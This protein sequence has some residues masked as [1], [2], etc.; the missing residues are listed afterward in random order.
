[1]LPAT[2]AEQL[3]PSVEPLELDDELE[4]LEELDEELL[5]LDD[6]LEDELEDEEPASQLC[7]NAQELSVPGVVVVHH[8]AVYAEPLCC[9]TSPPTA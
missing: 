5:E 7:A 1:M 2:K 4:E 3:S 6:E 8:L 9:I